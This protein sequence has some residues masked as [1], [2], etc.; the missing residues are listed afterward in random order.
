MVPFILKIGARCRLAVNFTRTPFD[1]VRNEQETGWTP[2]PVWASF[3]RDIS[4]ASAEIRTP[5]DPAP[6]EL[7]KLCYNWLSPHYIHTSELFS[8]HSASV[9]SFTQKPT[10][11][12]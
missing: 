7:R 2:E 11:Q 9:P 1:P 8:L 4:L 12:I 3:S 10:R 6:S 5:A